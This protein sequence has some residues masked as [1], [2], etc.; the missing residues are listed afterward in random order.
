MTLQPGDMLDR[1][2]VEA[3]I[4]EGSMAAVYRA[5]DTRLR[6]TVALKVYHAAGDAGG[7]AA[8][9]AALR[10]ARAAAAVHHPS[11][12]TVFDVD[13]VG[14][15]SFIA[16]EHVS[17]VS[18]R[19]L[20]G[21]GT[22]P[23]AGRFRWLVDVARALAA[24]HELSVIHRDVRPENIV[25]PPEGPVKVLDFGTAKRPR[26]GAPAPV[27]GDW[28]ITPSAATEISGAPEYLAP[29][30]IEGRKIDG[31]ADQFSWGVVAYE[32]LAG[33]PPWTRGASPFVT[34]SS[35]LR[36]EPAPFAPE[37]GV[38]PEVAAVVMR[39]L[40]KSPEDRFPSMAA[41]AD[42][43][44]P[45]AA[46]PSRPAIGANRQ[47]SSPVLPEGSAVSPV[48]PAIPSPVPPA[49][50]SP[51]AGMP[52]PRPPARAASRAGA[53]L[54]ILGRR[55]GH[56]SLAY[57]DVLVNV[58]RGPIS[59][60]DVHAAGDAGREMSRR[61]PA[62]IGSIN[63]AL[64]GVGLPDATTRAVAVA[65]LAESQRWLLGT[66]VVIEGE[67]FAA[68]AARAA[69]GMIQL[70]VKHRCPQAVFSDVAA[71]ARWLAPKCRLVATPDELAAAL[72]EA[73]GLAG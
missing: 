4:G 71:A 29:E 26:G 22:V 53:H 1:Y 64:A 10:E 67:G 20:V 68:S 14:D 5:F 31:R 32:L 27:P 70:A 54:E 34:L 46:P 73:R 40:A 8:V 48:P 7:A 66:A 41:V 19:R 49:I 47:P 43:L 37:L 12:A 30:R 33:A 36:D 15:A 25:V 60:G 56:L 62:G 61:H 57:G 9:A 23:A 18:L 72:A 50:P 35:I 38:P 55:G 63:V 16:M 6:R 24:A 39:A 17:G 44:D 21:D 13:Q 28:R 45:F 51:R 58:W 3:L 59:A 52:S 11:V 2:V 42:A 65:V 69:Y